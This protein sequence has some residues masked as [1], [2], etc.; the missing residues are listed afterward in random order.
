MKIA[1]CAAEA[2]PFAKRGGLGDVC[3]ALPLA[4]EK[5]GVDVSLFLPRYGCA[6]EEGFKIENVRDRVAH[7][8]LGKKVKVYFI[9]DEHLFGR[10]EVYGDSNGDYADNL[11][12]FQHYCAHVLD[13]LKQHKIKVDILHCHDWHAALIPV[14]LKERHASDPFFAKTKSILTI[15]NIAHQ[16]LFAGSDYP[17]LGLRPQQ[18]DQFEFYGKINFLKAGI[19][20]SD[21]VTTVSPQY[22]REIQTKDFGCGLDGVLGA[23]GDHII[24]ILNGLDEDIWSPE[25]DPLIAK[26]FSLKNHDKVKPENKQALQRQLG[27][28]EDG[29]VPLFGFL[30]RLWHQ[31]GVDL[32]LE[33]IGKIRERGAQIVLMGVGDEQFQRKFLD[34]AKR[35]PKKIAAQIKF[36]EKLAHRIYAGS[37]FFLMPSRFE[38]CGLSQM[39]SLHYGTIPV[40]YKTGGLADTVIDFRTDA[41]KG[42]G[43]VFDRYTKEEFLKTVLAAFDLFSDAGRMKQLRE[44]ALRSDFSWRHSAVEYKAL[45]RCL[46][47]E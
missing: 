23:R 21:Q 17:K 4:L 25:R 35:Y 36:D 44:N 27:L 40:V 5:I 20:C 38:P 12:R 33:V 32:L 18:F 34:W 42:N 37:D 14:Y 13:F 31:K 11:D 9:E 45:Y 8:V 16:G 19:M 2:F 22:A 30:S 6:R 24:G 3:G 39:I 46:L 41:A 10:E 29:D 43:L 1:F 28:P 47:S 26:K 7:T 15:H